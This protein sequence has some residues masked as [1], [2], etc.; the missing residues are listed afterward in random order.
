[1]KP[2]TRRA[3][4]LAIFLALA[5]SA[6]AQ[7]DLTIREERKV[8]V[9]GGQEV[10]QLAW[11]G[12]VR[13]YCEAVSP[14]V[15]MTPACATFAHGQAGR[16]LLRRLQGGVVLD[17][18]DPA[19]AFKDRG[20]GWTDGWSVL[21]RHAVREDDYERWLED[22]GAFLRA[23]KERPAASVLDLDDYDRDGK[24]LEFLIRTETGPSGRGLYAA[25][26]LIGGKLGFLRSTGRPDRVLVLPRDIWVALRDRG[27]PVLRMQTACG[28]KGTTLRSEQILTAT[29]G[30]ISVKGRDFDCA[31]GTPPV[32]KAE[33][34]G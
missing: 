27:G 24:A 14:E 12:P 34:E 29:D 11:V 13:D 18:F 5:G 9:D 20:N 2:W 10:W 3:L 32:L 7:A 31:V 17:Q 6:S 16:L 21:P 1:M 19:P 4:A 8:A 15:A 23:V 30:R 25:V 22:E 26:G 28:D 33:Y